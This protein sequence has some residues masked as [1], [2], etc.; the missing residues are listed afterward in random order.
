M[1]LAVVE[2]VSVGLLHLESQIQESLLINQRQLGLPVEHVVDI[3][4]GEREQVAIDSA[5]NFKGI[6]RFLLEVVGEP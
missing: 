2:I 3:G 1:H 4:Q 6:V 5:V